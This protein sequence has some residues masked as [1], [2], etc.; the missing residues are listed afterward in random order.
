METSTVIGFA[1]AFFTLIMAS[2]ALHELG[3][4]IPAKRFGVRVPKYF[5]GFGPTLWSTTR[6]E[7][8]YGIKWFPLGGF[9]R[10]LGMYPPPPLDDRPRAASRLNQLADAARDQEWQE[11]TPTDVTDKRLFYQKKTWQ[12]LVVMAGGPVMNLLIAFVLML[13]VT[14]LYGVYRAQTTVGYVQP[15]VLTDSTRTE[16][17]DTDP[18][19]PAAAAGLQAGDRVVSFNETMITSYSQLS[20]LIRA[21]LDAEA[22]LVVERGGQ[23]VAL[24]PVHTVIN[25]VADTLDPGRRLSAGWLGVSPKQEL[26]KGGPVEV[27]GD[28]WLQTKQSVVALV[29]FPVKV[30]HVMVGMVTGQPRDV[31]DPISI[32]GASTVAGQVIASDQVTPGAKVATFVSLLASV[33][34][35]LALFNFVPLPPLDG[36]HIAG[37]LYEWVRRK[38]ATLSKRPDPG[39]FDTAK[40]LPVAYGV[41]GLLLLSG[42]VLILADI[43]SPISLF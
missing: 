2:V 17:A 11:I 26:V 43:I 24:A 39:F 22:R 4:M 29:Q 14:G 13:G 18:K 36:G 31:Y 37:A 10:L 42:V 32:L 16:C 30:W 12:K 19:S 35:F 3:H 33:N 1:I 21:N 27:L 9:V 28:M 38:F 25:E 7:T 34:L 23:E 5:V 20:S 41:G 6:G 15:C 40:L 8:E